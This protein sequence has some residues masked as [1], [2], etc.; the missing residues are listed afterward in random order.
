MASGFALVDE[1]HEG[2]CEPTKKR[3]KQASIWKYH[4]KAEYVVTPLPVSLPCIPAVVHEQSCRGKESHEIGSLPTSSLSSGAAM[5][6][7]PEGRQRRESRSVFDPDV[8]LF[9]SWY[10]ALVRVCSLECVLD[11]FEDH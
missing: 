4:R 11:R 9:E 7:A 2:G 1:G 6:G 10:L 3:K 8:P 5:P